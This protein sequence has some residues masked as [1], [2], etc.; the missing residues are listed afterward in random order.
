MKLP[1]IAVPIMRNNRLKIAEKVRGKGGKI[2]ASLANWQTRDHCVS[3]C[4]EHGNFGVGHESCVDSCY[5]EKPWWLDKC[6]GQ[7]FC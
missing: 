7:R 1:T 6:N 3:A 2:I 5:W 4:N